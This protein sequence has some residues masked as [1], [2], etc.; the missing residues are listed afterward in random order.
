VGGGVA[1]AAGFQMTLATPADME[2]AYT[3]PVDTTHHLIRT[4]LSI[5]IFISVF[6]AKYRIVIQFLTVFRIFIPW[7]CENLDV[8]RF[9]QHQRSI[10]RAERLFLSSR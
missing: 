2:S 8:S 10:G 9:A 3:R 4:A 5:I 1:H 6:Y 7:T